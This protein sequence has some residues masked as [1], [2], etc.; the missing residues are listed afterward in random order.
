MSVETGSRSEAGVPWSAPP[1]APTRG[2]RV[3]GSRRRVLIP[4]ISEVRGPAASMRR[5]ALFRRMLAAGDI[6]AL[7]GAFLLTLEISRRPLG[8]TW[9]PSPRSRSCSSPRS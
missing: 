8:V 6:L 7:V 1:L 9:V 5:D 2:F 4:G 3:L